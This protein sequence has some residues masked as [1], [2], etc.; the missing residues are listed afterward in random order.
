MPDLILIN[1]GLTASAYFKKQKI[2]EDDMGSF[3]TAVVVAIGLA[4]GGMYL[5][6][7]LQ[8]RADEAFYYPTSVRI[9]THGN[10]HNLVGKDWYSA[11]EHGWA[12]EGIPTSNA[13]APPDS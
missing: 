6:D 7:K 11:K 2:M 3:A 5:L 9:P 13:A 10:T 1:I 4:I 8:L 12:N